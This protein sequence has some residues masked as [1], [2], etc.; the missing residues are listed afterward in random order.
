MNSMKLSETISYIKFLNNLIIKLDSD[1]L[2]HE[3][4]EQFKFMNDTYIYPTYDTYYASTKYKT[5]KKEHA[6][7]SSK[8]IYTF[9]EF[10]KD[11]KEKYIGTEKEPYVIEKNPYLRQFI[12]EPINKADEVHIPR[13]V[14]GVK[15]EDVA[16]YIEIS[17]IFKDKSKDSD[18]YSW[19]SADGGLENILKDAPNV[20]YIRYLI[21]KLNLFDIR[22]LNNFDIININQFY[23]EIVYDQSFRD[24]I[25][26]YQYCKTQILNKFYS[27]IMAENYSG[28]DNHILAIILSSMSSIVCSHR[29]ASYTSGNLNNNEVD[30]ILKLHNLE[31][32]VNENIEKDLKKNIVRN[33]IFNNFTGKS[34]N[35][36]IDIV[37]RSLQL[38]KVSDGTNKLY[39]QR[40]YFNPEYK[41]KP[42]SDN[43]DVI[44]ENLAT[45]SGYLSLNT[46]I[47]QEYPKL[48]DEEAAKG[49][50]DAGTSALSSYLSDVTHA[51]YADFDNSLAKN[52]RNKLKNFIKKQKVKY[53]SPFLEL[54]Y[55]YTEND[56]SEVVEDS[57]IYTL[58]TNQYLSKNFPAK[59]YKYLILTYAEI[60]ILYM[61]FRFLQYNYDTLPTKFSINHFVFTKI[62]NA[63]R[64]S[65]I[66]TRLKDQTFSEQTPFKPRITYFDSLKKY[67]DISNVID[68]EVVLERMKD[69]IDISKKDFD[70]FMSTTSNY[71]QLEFIDKYSKEIIRAYNY[72]ETHYKNL[73]KTHPMSKVFKFILDEYMYTNK[74]LTNVNIAKLVDLSEKD[75]GEIKNYTDFFKKNTSL[76]QYLTNYLQSVKNQANA[77]A[78]ITSLK[79]FFDDIK[80]LV[81]SML[82]Y[83][84]ITTNVFFMNNINIVRT[85]IRIATTLMNR[86]FSSKSKIVKAYV[87]DESTTN[88]G[89]TTTETNTTDGGDDNTTTGTDTDTDATGTTGDG[90]TGTD[91]TDTT[92]DGNNGGTGDKKPTGTRNASL[93]K[94]IIDKSYI[95]YLKDHFKCSTQETI[96]YYVYEELYTN[97]DCIIE[98]KSSNNLSFVNVELT[99]HTTIDVVTE[100]LKGNNDHTINLWNTEI[101][102]SENIEYDV[103]DSIPLPQNITIHPRNVLKKN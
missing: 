48:T 11:Q 17:T 47:A 99:V 92:G 45:L 66:E 42:S 102:I 37:T 6:E 23:N 28:Y 40:I 72:T 56:D 10:K 15:T 41:V 58:F 3:T 35:Y 98:V 69:F 65:S 71:K 46:N 38:G 83:S 31:N 61:Y 13:I 29:L 57:I 67:L 60:L 96:K 32:I 18:L 1:I 49:A 55:A 22:R 82:K 85:H 25:E 97:T 2:R 73:S 62:I 7:D 43:H 54:Q 101:D 14:N 88:A 91:N 36:I 100:P 77:R 16:D 34:D 24:Y 20:L 78:K 103:S 86:Y 75:V 79:I 9:E 70:I 30:Y 12:G 27:P 64:T 8:P 39:A 44:I 26:V 50:Y 80:Q 94:K 90:N 51:T 63:A 95:I 89:I 52:Y 68:D 81:V 84:N 4:R 59:E 33:I 19:L 93:A 53:K 87:I 5:S 74:Y 21:S 76:K